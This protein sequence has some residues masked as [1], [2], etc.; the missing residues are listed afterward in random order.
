MG[1]W[2]TLLAEGLERVWVTLVEEGQGVERGRVWGT[3]LVAAEE[4][5]GVERGRVWVTLVAEEEDLKR[6]RVWVRLVAEE[7]QCRWGSC[8]MVP[9]LFR[10]GVGCQ[11]V[12]TMLLLR[13]Q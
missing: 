2:E 4:D 11:R 5:Q 13:C 9:G 12:Q 8:Q 7:G 10:T 6:G 3:L 1:D